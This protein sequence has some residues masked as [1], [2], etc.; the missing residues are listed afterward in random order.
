MNFEKHLL[1]VFGCFNL[2]NLPKLR[3]LVSFETGVS[4][5][6]IKDEDISYPVPRCLLRDTIIHHTLLITQ[7]TN[8]L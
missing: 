1:Q 5:L 2:T 4:A 7:Y 3:C 8:V 6:L